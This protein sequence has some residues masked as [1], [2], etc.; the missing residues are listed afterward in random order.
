VADCGTPEFEITEVGRP[1]HGPTPPG[2]ADPCSRTSP[3]TVTERAEVIELIAGGRLGR[4][5]VELPDQLR[6]RH[7]ESVVLVMLGLDQRLGWPAVG[8]KIGAA[9]EEVRRLEGMPA[10]SPGRL[11]SDRLFA[12]GSELPRSLFV[13]YR[14]T[15][16]EFAFGLGRDVPPRAHEYTEQEV[17]SSVESVFPVLE[18]G[19]MVFPDWYQ[20]SGYFGPSLDNGGGGVLVYGEPISDWQTR[21]L[22]GARIELYV[23][24]CYV[25]AGFG[26]AAMGHPLTSL[27][28]MANWA[29]RRGIGLRKGEVISTGTCTGHCFVAEGDHVVGDFGPLGKVEVFHARR[30]SELNG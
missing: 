27:T 14:E 17:A 7:W 8:W 30:E 18:I 6:T 3:L 12:S 11:Y 5:T 9:S 4:C 24:G 10:P 20:A 16:C 28:W 23:N 15:E 2:G 22:D 21:A 29:S 26:R 19:D 25:K 1:I 13:N